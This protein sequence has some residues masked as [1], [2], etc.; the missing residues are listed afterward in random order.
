MQV[1]SVSPVSFCGPGSKILSNARARDSYAA[2][3]IN[4]A[5]EMR[6]PADQAT[7]RREHWEKYLQERSQATHRPV[8]ME[9]VMEPTK[10]DKNMDRKR[11]RR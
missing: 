4:E 1:Y 3:V 5:A 6:H 11:N 10:H 9:K 2:K 8:D 7:F